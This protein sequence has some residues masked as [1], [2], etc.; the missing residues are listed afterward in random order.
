[1]SRFLELLLAA[2]VEFISHPRGWLSRRTHQRIETW[3]PHRLVSWHRSQELRVQNKRGESGVWEVRYTHNKRAQ[4]L[5][6][7]DLLKANVIDEVTTSLYE[8]RVIPVHNPH[9][10]KRYAD[11]KTLET[12]EQTKRSEWSST[13]AWS[14]QSQTHP[15]RIRGCGH[16]EHWHASRIVIIYFSSEILSLKMFWWCHFRFSYLGVRMYS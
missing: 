12:V 14:I 15:S 8:P 11:T 7:F 10:I 13:S 5:L 6:N 1:M 16:G 3:G 2:I 9:K 4:S